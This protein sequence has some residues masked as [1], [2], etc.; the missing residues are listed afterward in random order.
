L[1]VTTA[2]IAAKMQQAVKA[3]HIQNE[4]P[5]EEIVT[6]SIGI[7]VYENAN[8]ATTEELVEVCDRALY[9]AKQNGRN[10]IESASGKTA[11]PN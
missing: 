11:A 1:P 9:R 4:T 10:R 2:K 5:I 3:L 7:A 6:I 8:L